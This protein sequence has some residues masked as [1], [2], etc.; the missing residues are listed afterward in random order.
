MRAAP[1][2]NARAACSVFLALALGSE[3]GLETLTCAFEASALLAPVS[4]LAC[5]GPLLYTSSLAPHPDGL[6]RW[7]L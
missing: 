4:E 3:L 6:W 5:A 2:L 1:T 7:G